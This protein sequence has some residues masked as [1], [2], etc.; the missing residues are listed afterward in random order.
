LEGE[1][2]PRVTSEVSCLPRYDT[3]PLP[4][5]AHGQRRVSED[6]QKRCDIRVSWPMFMDAAM[7]RVSPHI[8]DIAGTK[9]LG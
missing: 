1:Q 2:G 7:P 5:V 4:H 6:V 9:I 3:T 8:A